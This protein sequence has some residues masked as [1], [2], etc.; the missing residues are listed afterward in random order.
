MDDSGRLSVLQERL[1]DRLGRERYQLWVGPHTLIEYVDEKLRIGCPTEFEMN[2]VRSRLHDAL[3]SCSQQ[4]WQREVSIQYHVLEKSA[5]G[6]REMATA[7]IEPA[8]ME[9]AV[10]AAAAAADMAKRV[11]HLKSKPN[12]WDASCESGSLPKRPGLRSTFANFVVGPSNELACRTARSVAGSLGRF[13]PLFLFG[14]PGV[15]KTHLVYA[16]LQQWQRSQIRVRAVRLTAEQFTAEFLDALNRRALP[17]FR[18][19]YRSVDALV[20]DDMHFLIGKRATL[21]E[22]LYTIDTLYERGRQI[23]LTSDRSPGDLQQV[24]SELVSRVSGGLAIP[25]AMP[26]YATRLGITRRFATQMGLPAG[27]EVL[28]LI[29][30]Q[31]VGSARQ[32]CGA[33]NLLIATSQAQDS[34]LTTDLARATLVEYIQQNA[35]T[36]RLADIQRAVCHVFGVEPTSLKSKRKTR[37]LVEPRMLAMWLARKYT[38]AAL[39][40]IGA[41]FGRSSHSTVISAHKKIEGLVSQGAQ[42]HVADRACHVEEAIRQVE[43]VMRTA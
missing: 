22:L 12:G 27:E 4:V 34:E 39:G 29:A 2:W 20:I 19:K 25:L 41:Y 3:H 26:E 13:G 17:S 9:S 43:A 42:L 31:V 14:P 21:D 28:T 16:M 32:I 11:P 37:S 40:E 8:E 15:G 6:T 38:R 18:H 36:V 23:V 7:K 35:P 24:S 33:I 5:L 10:G 1:A 30:A